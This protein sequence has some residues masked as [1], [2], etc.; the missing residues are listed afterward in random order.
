M[1]QFIVTFDEASALIL[2]PSAMTVAL[3][4]TT[5]LVGGFGV[6]GFGVVGLGV[7]GEGLGVLWPDPEEPADELAELDEELDE[8]LEELEEHDELEVELD[9]LDEL[10]E[11][12]D[13]VAP[14]DGPFGGVG[15][16][17][18]AKDRK[19]T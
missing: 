13:E 17:F 15:V 16:V 19:P 18:G 4:C 12:L 11:E 10:D 7:V 9:E 5:T 6:E 3:A 8:E 1:P 2:V 14:A